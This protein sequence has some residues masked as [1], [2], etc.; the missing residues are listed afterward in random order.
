LIFNNTIPSSTPEN[1]LL[2]ITENTQDWLEYTLQPLARN[3]SVRVLYLVDVYL[4]GVAS[5]P[6]FEV[7]IPN[8]GWDSGFNAYPAKIDEVLGPIFVNEPDGLPVGFDLHP[9]HIPG[10]HRL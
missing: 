9:F 7:A 1:A 10:D 8:N 2:T 5:T 3:V 4:R 6:S